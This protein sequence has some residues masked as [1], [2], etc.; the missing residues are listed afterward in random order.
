MLATGAA[1]GALTRP[2]GDGRRVVGARLE[3][4]LDVD[5]DA[6]FP[7]DLCL[8]PPLHEAPLLFI[9]PELPFP[10]EFP[11]PFAL[12]FPFGDERPF[13][14]IVGIFIIF[15]I[16]GLIIF[17]IMAGPIGAVTR[18]GAFVIVTAIGAGELMAPELWLPFPFPF[19]EGELMMPGFWAPFPFPCPAEGRWA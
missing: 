7:L 16:M 17:I 4:L 12:P 3:H 14:W 1:V 9:P 10:I 13:E 11:F 5:G 19:D 8:D 2:V 15:I 18:V 6:P